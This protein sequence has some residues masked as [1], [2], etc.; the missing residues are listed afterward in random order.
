[1]EQAAQ[2][3]TSERKLEAILSPYLEYLHWC[4]SLHSKPGFRLG[5]QSES[6]LGKG[7]GGLAT[8][9]ASMLFMTHNVDFVE[10]KYN[11]Y[12]F[13]KSLVLSKINHNQ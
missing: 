10:D 2:Q 6:R 3:V 5:E 4:R 7:A 9:R 8:N 12:L 1:M 11:F 13:G